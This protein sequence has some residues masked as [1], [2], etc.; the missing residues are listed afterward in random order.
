VNRTLKRL[1]GFVKPYTKEFIGGI[2]CILL[3]NLFSLSVPWIVKEILGQVLADK[4]AF[5]L[6]L[7]VLITIGAMFAKGVFYYGQYYLLQFVVQRI[8]VDLRNRMYTS[9]QRLSLSFYEKTH[10][11]DIISRMTN[12][13]AAVE[14]TLLIGLTDTIANAT[15][16]A[17]ILVMMF[18]IHW[19][20]AIVTL[21][22]IPVLGIA[23]GKFGN[24]L[25]IVTRNIQKK[26]ADITSILQETLSAIRVVKAFTMENHEFERFANENK[27]NFDISM[28][29]AQVQATLPPVVELV[30][31]LAVAVIM[32]YGGH[33]VIAGRL[34][35]SDF[36]GFILYV[37]MASA[38]LRGL[39]VTSNTLQRAVASA[40][41]VF[42]II[43]SKEMVEE[44]PGAMELPKIKGKVEFRKVNFSYEQN[45]V[46]KDVSFV[47]NPG[48]VVALVGPSG[49]GKTT[50][51]NLI[52]R[53]YDAKGEILIDDIDIKKVSLYSLRS[54]LGIVPQETVLFSGT[55]RDNIAYGSTNATYED[56]VAAAVAANA[57]DFIM[58]FPDGYGTRVGERGETLSGG[59]RQ[60]IAIARAILRN[61]GILIFDE[62]TS[63][64][65]TES[66]ALVH[67]AISNLLQGRTAFV[68]AHRLSTIQNADKIL[69]F[70]NGRLVES[71]THARLL[72]EGGLYKRLRDSQVM[73][74]VEAQ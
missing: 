49:A 58:Q 33:E 64:L 9:L 65:D 63:A 67:E 46:L 14:T 41:R 34:T 55:I 22:I 25:R 17:G 47:V 60:R 44:I 36:T 29:G 23:M 11:G 39:S 31:A 69:V 19:K 52:A 21:V 40:E 62:A 66:E 12:D 2:V 43:D 54:Q 37:T 5:M 16:L 42:E 24:K 45:E 50:V 48:E 73:G 71:G 26:A 18:Y 38:P 32:L 28:K 61:P 1:L 27:R 4:N 72:T 68:I 70:D 53:F 10:V 7:L 74:E 35:F 15:L 3:M 30:G 59:Q 20:L 6:N 56:I 13:T 51:V 57:H 8:T